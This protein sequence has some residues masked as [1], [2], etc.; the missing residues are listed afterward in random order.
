MTKE[1]LKE[2]KIKIIT[3]LICGFISGI[4][5]AFAPTICTWGWEILPKLF[6]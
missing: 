3:Y 4:L 1:Q 5:L 2:L 6:N